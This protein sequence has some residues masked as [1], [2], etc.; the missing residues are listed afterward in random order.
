M[1]APEAH[2]DC[3]VCRSL[4]GPERIE[5]LYEDDFWQVRHNPAPYG[6]AGW[7]QMVSKRHVRGPAHFSPAEALALGPALCRFERVLLEVT[8]AVC[9]YTAAMG[10]SSPHFHAHMVPR[11]PSMPREVRGWAVF[12]LERAARTGEIQVEGAEVARV[13]AA[14]RAALAQA[15]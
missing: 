11:Y 2:P 3:A 7:M 14:Y 5:P 13:C 9:I 15:V 12:D 6:V 4:S 10:E 8:G 1:S